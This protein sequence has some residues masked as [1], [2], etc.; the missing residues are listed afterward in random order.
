MFCGIIGKTLD[1]KLT[2]AIADGFHTFSKGCQKISGFHF[3]IHSNQESLLSQD[4]YCVLPQPNPQ[5][6][7]PRDCD[8]LSIADKLSRLTYKEYLDNPAM[9]ARIGDELFLINASD[10]SGSVYVVSGMGLKDPR[11]TNGHN[12]KTTNQIYFST[13]I[14]LFREIE[15]F[16][17]ISEIIIEVKPK[18]MW[19][20]TCDVDGVPKFRKFQLEMDFKA[21]KSKDKPKDNDPADWWKNGGEPPEFSIEEE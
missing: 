1:E 4:G 13:K 17:E 18:Q 12:P 2:K 19:S 20:I 14:D 7:R 6:N 11:L 8:V 9:W 5:P 10:E 15:A 16:S 21:F 3:D